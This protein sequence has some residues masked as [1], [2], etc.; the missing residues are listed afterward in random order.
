VTDT[1]GG[2]DQREEP[3]TMASATDEER[4]QAR[5][6]FR[7]KLAAAEARMTPEKRDRVRAAFGLDSRA[8]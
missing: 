6:E 4:A 5:A 8:A 3:D 2:V 1:L 7:R